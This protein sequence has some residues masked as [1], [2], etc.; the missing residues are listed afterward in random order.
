[1]VVLADYVT[2]DQGTGCVHT[3]PG[4]GVED[5]ETGLRYGLDIYNPVDAAGRFVADLPLVGG[6]SVWKANRTIIA[7]LQR[8]G[9]LLSEVQVEHSYPHCWRCKHPTIF[10][11]TEQ[12]FISMD[13]A[14]LPDEGG[15]QTGLRAKALAE[16]KQVRWIPSWGEDRISNMV[17]YR[18]DWCISRQRAWG[19]RSWPSTAPIAATSWRTSG[20][21]SMWRP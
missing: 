1:M 20:L 12:W 8:R 6:V 4:H 5:Y 15:G 10:R 3:A 17:A 19:S 21:P 9:L 7:E 18:S 11:A 13:A 2:M 16:I 14:V